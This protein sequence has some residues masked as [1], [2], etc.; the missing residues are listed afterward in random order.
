MVPLT[1]GFLSELFSDYRR[2]FPAIDLKVEEA[3][4]TFDASAILSGRLDIAFMLGRPEIVGCTTK[5]LWSED[6]YLVV[7]EGHLTA[8]LEAVAL[9]LIRQENFILT[10]DAV[11]A[12][13]EAFLVRKLSAPGFRPSITFQGVGRENLFSMVRLGFGITLMT[14]SPLEMSYPG[15]RFV[16]LATEEC[17]VC[18]SMIWRDANTN[19]VLKVL[20]D[21]SLKY[22]NRANSR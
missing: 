4:S 20:I 11:G 8:G 3:S 13:A 16:R 22:A 15:L 2:D 19:P 5:L 7:P 6:I 12:E 10:F 9:E 17:S 21:M 14:A 18:S 1:S